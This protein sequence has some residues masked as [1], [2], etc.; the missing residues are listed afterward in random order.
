MD[1]CRFIKRQ[2]SYTKLLYFKDGT[3]KFFDFAITEITSKDGYKGFFKAFFVVAT[4]YLGS[5]MSVTTLALPIEADSHKYR[6]TVEHELKKEIKIEDLDCKFDMKSYKECK[7]ALYKNK[8]SESSL[9]AL[10][11]F[12]SLLGLFAYLTGGLSIVG[13]VFHPYIHAVKT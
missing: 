11:A 8:L 1:I 6:Y 13:F 7:L 10:T 9:D 4:L 2:M 3:V 5:L 12:Q